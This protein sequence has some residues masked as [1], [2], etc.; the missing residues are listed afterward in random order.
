MLER[1]IPECPFAVERRRLRDLLATIELR[2]RRWTIAR[3]VVE[4]HPEEVSNVV[5]LHVLAATHRPGRAREWLAKIRLSD[6]PADVINL[7]DEIAQRHK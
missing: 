6:G 5:S 1:L 4:A 2:R 7:A 3:R